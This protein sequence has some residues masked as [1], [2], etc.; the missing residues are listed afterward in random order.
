M[1]SPPDR[2]GSP[3]TLADH[4]C[5]AAIAEGPTHGWAL[6]KLLRPDGD[7]GRIWTLS[8]GLTYRS[9]E[10]L[11]DDRA[12]D[13]RDGGRRATLTATTS[14]AA[15]AAAWL[16]EPVEHVRDLRTEFLLKLRLHER[17]GLDPTPLVERQR[18]LLR[19]ALDTL[20]TGTPVDAVGLWR[21]ESAMAARRFLDRIGQ[22]VVSSP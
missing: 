10:R 6:V 17:A 12:V 21:Q 4:V 5:L 9:I 2:S 8:R 3:R 16:G 19:P 22:H 18:S 11:V 13:R 15:A 1:A 7:L 20:G 14:G